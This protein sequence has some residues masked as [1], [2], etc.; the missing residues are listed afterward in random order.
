VHM[1]LLLLLPLPLRRL[2][3][4]PKVLAGIL[5]TSTGRCWSSDTYNPCPGGAGVEGVPCCVAVW[6]GQCGPA[7]MGQDD[8]LVPLP[9]RSAS[10]ATQ[11][12]WRTCLPAEDTRADLPL[13]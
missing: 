9:S 7:P 5:N 1:L 4:D 2:G 11:G 8:S 12:L 13:R 6:A 10:A 3:M